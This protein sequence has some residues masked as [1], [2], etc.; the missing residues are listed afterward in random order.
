MRDGERER[1]GRRRRSGRGPQRGA[2][3]EK[4]RSG[5]RQFVT[6][7]VAHWP[8]T[9]EL[10]EGEVVGGEAVGG[11][12]KAQGGRGGWGDVGRGCAGGVVGGGEAGEE[13]GA[14]GVEA[15][16]EPVAEEEVKAVAG[17]VAGAGA[18]AAEGRRV[19]VDQMGVAREA[20]SVA[21]GERDAEPAGGFIEDFAGGGEGTSWVRGTIWGFRARRRTANSI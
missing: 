5:E 19:G 6:Q 17:G 8:G 15:G 3:A 4:I 14:F 1:R 2:E 10:G 16:G 12:T 7:K 20:E 18:G 13:G 11:R 9:E 21:R